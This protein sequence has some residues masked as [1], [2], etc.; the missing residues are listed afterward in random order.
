M[1]S[2]TRTE[3][4]W[5]DGRLFPVKSE[6]PSGRGAWP[7]SQVF[8][9][10][11]LVAFIEGDIGD[12]EIF[13]GD[14]ATPQRVNDALLFHRGIKPESVSPTVWSGVPNSIRAVLSERVKRAE[15]KLM[16]TWRSF[17]NEEA[18]T[19][20]MFSDLQGTISEDGW[21]VDVS[22]VEFSKQSKEPE[23]GT[24][25][26]VVLDAS[27][28]TGRRSFKTIWLQAKSLPA[29][30]SAHTKLPRLSEQLPRARAYCDSSFGLTY[31]PDGV[32]VV[33]GPVQPVQPLDDLLGAAMRCVTGDQRVDALK[34][35][36][37]RRRV[38]QI[39]LTETE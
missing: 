37:S 25:V 4:Y 9:T 28:Q 14:Q 33:N 19:G 5:R 3:A 10:H 36:L 35:S 2:T 21:R 8:N 18:M 15:A 27:D 34:N 7:R 39:L 38:F 22:F 11:E 20:A 12:L 30:P 24:D 32:F 31:T 1:R 17:S 26:A 13:Q 29:K 6:R 16:N 23:T